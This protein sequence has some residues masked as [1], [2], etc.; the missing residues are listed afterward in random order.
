MLSSYAPVIFAKKAYCEELSM[1]E[2]TNRPFEPSSM[3]AK[4][5][6]CHGNY[7]S[8]CLMYRGNV[9]L[10]GVNA[11]ASSIQTKRTIQFV[12]WFPIGFKCGINYQPPTDVLGDDLQPM[13]VSL[14]LSHTEHQPAG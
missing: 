1:A 14:S 8:C 6:P 13:L 11:I 5:N 12:D 7:M 4:R 9:V 2:I 3:M 10:K